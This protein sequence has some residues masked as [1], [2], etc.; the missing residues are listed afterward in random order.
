MSLEQMKRWRLILG[1]SAEDEFQSCAKQAGWLREGCLLSGDLTAI[2]EALELV[3]SCEDG[4]ASQSLDLSR[5][6]WERTPGSKHGAVRG[7][8]FPRVARWLGEI[9]RLFPTGIV[10]LRQKGAIERKGLKQLLCALEM[11]A[12]LEPAGG[13]ASV[14][15]TWK[16]RLPCNASARAR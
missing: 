5:E 9:R 14:I 10:T 15:R 11:L 7:R 16:D 2:D 8:S 12:R 3:Y 1:K 6:E 4:E 13:L